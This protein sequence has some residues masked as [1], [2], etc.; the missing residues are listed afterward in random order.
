MSTNVNHEG[1]ERR[2]SAVKQILERHGLEATAITPIAYIEHCP[3]RFNNFI[4][5]V[6]LA[7]PALP[8]NFPSTLPGVC[9][10]PPEGVSALIVRLSN[11]LAE[12]LNNTHRSQ[13]EV[14]SQAVAR[15]ALAKAGLPSLVPAVYAWS[16][17]KYGADNAA[18]AEDGFGWTLAELKPGADLD[19]EF[20][21]L[22]LDEKRDAVS[23]IAAILGA[24]QQVELPPSADKFG[25]LTFD[26]DTQEMV[27]GQM[28]LVKGGPW[29]S[30]AEVWVGKIKTQLADADRSPVL[31]GWKEGGVRERVEKFLAEGGVDKALV[32]VDV[33]LRGLVHGDFTT[34]NILFDSATKRISGLLDFDFSSVSHPGDEFLTGL[35]DIGGGLNDE[36]SKFAEAI[37][38]GD[39]NVKPEGL[40]EEQS[41]KWEVAKAWENAAAEKGLKRP[42]T[43]AGVRKLVELRK[44]ETILCPF[45]LGN[46]FRLSRM[47]EED[48]VKQRAE[49][50]AQLV[51]W[52]VGYGY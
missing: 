13:N 7:S 15:A 37:L 30:Y 5:K 14:A 18:P 24:L 41:E 32:G 36:R 49:T 50:E 45:N 33:G 35:W 51:E 27:S 48:K 11:P 4:Y 2:M 12:G 10:P 8:M 22:T 42:S 39:F 34:N 25:A 28:P 38:S 29:P 6:E 46:E 47:K 26:D 43:L 20:P 19:G 40:D 17:P 23:Q 44:L 9:S 3:F 1:F 52:L 16:P 31:K 21:S